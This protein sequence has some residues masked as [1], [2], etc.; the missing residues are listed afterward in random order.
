MNADEF[1]PDSGTFKLG[2]VPH[3][4]RSSSKVP[5]FDA[6]ISPGYDSNPDFWSPTHSPT[7]PICSRVLLTISAKFVFVFL[8]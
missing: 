4:H 8:I 6:P 7:N 5:D 2:Q 1:F 3:P